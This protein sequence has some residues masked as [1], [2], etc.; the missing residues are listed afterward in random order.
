MPRLASPN[1]V[2]I[3]AGVATLLLVNAAHLLFSE[4][5]LGIAREKSFDVISA[6]IAG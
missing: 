2:A 6:P 1:R 3:A 5:W 4:G